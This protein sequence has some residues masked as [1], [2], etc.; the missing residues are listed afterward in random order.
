[1]FELE[2]VARYRLDRAP[3]VQALAQVR[4]PLIA[5]L[6]TIPGVAPLQ[7]RLAELFPYMEQ[8]HVQE[9]GLLV[10]PAGLAASEGQSSITWEFT[11]DDGRLLV[12]TAGSATLSI[13]AQYAGI[14]DFAERFC[15]VLIALGEIE[16]VRRCDRLGVRYLSLAEQ[17]PGDEQAWA[18]WFRPEVVGWVGC[19]IVTSG[20]LVSS[21]T[22]TELAEAVAHRA[23]DAPGEVH[24]LIRNG[25]VP[26]GAIVP[27]VPPTQIE[28][29]SYLLDLDLF[30]ATPQRYD[31]DAVGEQFLALHGEID[32]FFRWTLTPEGADHFGLDEPV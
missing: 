4:F 23:A 12:L 1:M 19:G 2:E 26:A 6:Q 18:R 30:V 27:G 22:Q 28:Q 16:Q 15:S 14:D 13:G 21:I 11:D 20:D 8:K 24:A 9:I 5:H 29:P 10:G 17:A 7:D 25:I 32:R 3:L 31:A